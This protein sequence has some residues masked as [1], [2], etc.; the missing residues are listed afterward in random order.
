M[1]T[2]LLLLIAALGATACSTTAGGGGGGV[3]YIAGAA[4]A[5]T[6]L[7]DQCGASGTQAAVVHCTNAVWVAVNTCASGQVCTVKAGV[8]GCAG[9][10]SSSDTVSSSGDGLIF[11]AKTTPTDIDQGGTDAIVADIPI[12]VDIVKPVDVIKPKDVQPLDTGPTGATWGTCALSDTACTQACIQSSCTGPG[13]AC[14]N[15]ADCAAYQTCQQGCSATPI[16]MPVQSG[17]PVP[18]NA[19]ESQVDYCYRVCGLQATGPALALD[20]A[21]LTCVIGDCIDCS[22][23]ASGGI[24]QAQCQASCGQEYYCSA[25]LNACLGD[26]NCLAAFGCLL[27]CAQGDTT[28]ENNCINNAAGNGATLFGTFNDCANTNATTCTAP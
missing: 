8:P 15:N 9:T 18:Q 28:C 7:T 24:T 4:C 27:Q 17:T 23:S 11:D 19:G 12:A 16:Q 5:S 14:A 26:S 13:Q 22:Q 10:A 21:Y 3:A 20:Q 1:S 2:R 6:L 25:S